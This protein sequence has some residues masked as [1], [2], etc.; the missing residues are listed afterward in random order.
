MYFICPLN[1]TIIIIVIFHAGETLV[2]LHDS[3]NILAIISGPAFFLVI[4]SFIALTTVLVLW[5]MK[6]RKQK[7]MDAEA[8]GG[9]INP[10]PAET[11]GRKPTCIK[12]NRNNISIVPNEAYALVNVS[13]CNKVSVHLCIISRHMQ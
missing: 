12:N 4:L 10:T 9:G 8:N 1:H 6:P 3:T 2:S 7:L 11:N 13:K 5:R